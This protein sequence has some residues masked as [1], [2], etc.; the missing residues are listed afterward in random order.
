MNTVS[1]RVESENR[2][3]SNKGN[4][5][6]EINTGIGRTER[7]KGGD[8]ASPTLAPAGAIPSP[9]CEAGLP[10]PEAE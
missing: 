2:R 3:I 6:Q 8:K 9:R 10:G 5:I 1:L 7:P 4:L